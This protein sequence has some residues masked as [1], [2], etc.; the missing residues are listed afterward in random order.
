MVGRRSVFV[1][2]PIDIVGVASLLLDKFCRSWCSSWNVHWVTF[3]TEMASTLHVLKPQDLIV[4]SAA[5]WQHKLYITKQE[6]GTK[7]F[8]TYTKAPLQH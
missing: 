6:L 7:T 8:N 4:M 2:L 3:G 5:P 1:Q